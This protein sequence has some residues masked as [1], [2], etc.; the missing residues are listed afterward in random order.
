MTGRA[1][2]A[3]AYGAPLAF[4]GLFFAYPLAAIVDR[5]LRSGGGDTALEVLTDPLTREVVWFT[6]WQAVASTALTLAV[7]LPAALVI[8]RFRFRG[9]GLVRALVLVP[10][11]L[12]T[13]VVAL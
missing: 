6:F 5:G 2:R 1:W 4:L 7:A 3:L 9:R 10:F 11:V 13:V 8:G 12:P